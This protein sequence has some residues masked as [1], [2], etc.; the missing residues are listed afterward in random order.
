MNYFNYIF[1][2]GRDRIFKHKHSYGANKNKRMVEIAYGFL[3]RS[4]P[5][6]DARMYAL[7][8]GTRGTEARNR[9]PP[10]LRHG[11][12]GTKARNRVPP[13]PTRDPGNRGQESGPPPSPTRDPE[14]RGQESG[15]PPL[16]DAGPG[17]PGI[18]EPKPGS[19]V[20]HRPQKL[21]PRLHSRFPKIPKAKYVFQI[22]PKEHIFYVT[23]GVRLAEAHFR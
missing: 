9:V 14:N 1:L 5:Q 21:C 13:S 8:R 19:G 4:C 16:S 11:T 23:Q 2:I 3:I 22:S 20:P 18:W 10:P 15:S 7:R 17:E 12:R 6:D